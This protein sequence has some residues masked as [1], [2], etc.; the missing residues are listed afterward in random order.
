SKH[1]SPKRTTSLFPIN[2]GS[3]ENG[4]REEQDQEPQDL[5]AGKLRLKSYSRNLPN[6]FVKFLS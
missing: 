3:K 1:Q 5:F 6:G 2:N 4:I